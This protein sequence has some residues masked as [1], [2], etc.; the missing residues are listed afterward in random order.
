MHIITL[1]CS[2]IYLRN[3]SSLSELRIFEPSDS[4]GPPLISFFE[5]DKLFSYCCSFLAEEFYWE[6]DSYVTMLFVELPF[7]IPK[8]L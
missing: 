5:L 1:S 3:S 2:S 8:F 7:F 6:H 4:L